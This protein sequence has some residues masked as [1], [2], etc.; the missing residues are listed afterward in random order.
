METKR[1]EMSNVFLTF[2]M[3]KA[4]TEAAVLHHGQKRK[5]NGSPFIS[6]PYAVALILSNYTSNEDI[7]IAGL[8]HDTLEEVPGYT[9]KDLERDFGDKIA[10]IV[11]QVTEEEE[12]GDETL[13]RRTWQKRKEGYL[14]NIRN[15]NCEALMVCCADKIHNLTS[16]ID[17]YKEVGEDLWKEFM[18][19][20]E[21]ELW[22]YES[23]LAIL[24]ERLDSEIVKE[25][26]KA[27]L[28]AKNLSLFELKK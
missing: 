16:L 24:K 27:Y 10:Q 22:F 20:P 14:D 26:E 1:D 21:R 17:D 25:L 18:A 12:P 23:V 19:P 9:I 4:V 13:R 3:R 8:L 11:K 7:I 6:H 5:I 15:A 28:E 2:K